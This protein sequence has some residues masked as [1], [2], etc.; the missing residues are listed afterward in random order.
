MSKSLFQAKRTC[1]LGKEAVISPV[2]GRT[3]IALVG[4]LGVGPL[5][6]LGL[7]RFDGAAVIDCEIPPSDYNKQK[8]GAVARGGDAPL[9]TF[10]PVQS[11]RLPP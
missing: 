8:C 4:E 5:S 1:G 6:N 2:S 11:S 3:A 9:L 10:V 7:L